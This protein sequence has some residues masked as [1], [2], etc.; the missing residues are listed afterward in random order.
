[1]KL[2][3]E[4]E[5]ETKGKSVIRFSKGL[6]GL[7]LPGEEEASDEDLAADGEGVEVG[8]LANWLYRRVVTLGLEAAVLRSL[9]TGGFAALTDLLTAY[10]LDTTGL[11]G[12]TQTINPA[13][14]D[15]NVD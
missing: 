11:H 6:R 1:L 8:R 4:Y 7:L 15:N 5:R 13:G 14:V 3:H 2:W 9:D 12:P 10:H